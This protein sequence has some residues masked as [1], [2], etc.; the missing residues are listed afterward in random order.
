MRTTSIN[1][2]ST[3]AGI[4]PVSKRNHTYRGLL[5]VLALLIT[6][7][8]WSQTLTGLR[9]PHRPPNISMAAP[10]ASSAV[11]TPASLRYKFIPIATPNSTYA[12]AAGI[13]NAGVV[14]GYYQDSSANNHGF[15]WQNGAFQTVDYP[16]AVETIIYGVNNRGIAMADYYVDSTTAH[17]AAYSVSTGTWTPLPD[18][19]NYS[20]NAGYCINDSGVAVG[21]RDWIAPG[22]QRLY[23]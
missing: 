7:S 19:P 8:A 9:A 16:G 15:V 14:T 1:Q 3:L 4:P 2:T 20:V 22:K 12:C 17:T 21:K 18:I 6:A 13:N 10:S 11:D 5:P 23:S